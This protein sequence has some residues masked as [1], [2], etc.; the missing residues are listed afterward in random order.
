MGCNCRG[1]VGNAITNGFAGIFEG[2]VAV[3]MRKLRIKDER[4]ALSTSCG[5]LAGCLLGVGVV[6]TIAWTILGLS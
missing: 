6:L 5:K 4:T 2:Y 1:A 3:K